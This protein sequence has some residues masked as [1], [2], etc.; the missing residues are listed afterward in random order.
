MF[1]TSESRNVS[2]MGGFFI[3]MGLVFGGAII[4]IVIGGGIFALMAGTKVLNIEQAMLNP[5]NVDALRLLQFIST[6]FMFF[7]PAVAFAYI[8]NKK[9]YKWLGY[10]EG[11]NYRQ[12]ILVLAV[13]FICLPLTGALAELNSIIPIPA[14]LEAKFKRMEENYEK[15]VEAVAKIRSFGEYLLSL[16]MIA[17][18]PALFEETLFRGGLQ[19]ILIE[20]TKKPITA[21]IV[22]SILFSIVHASYYGFLPRVGLGIVL[23]L[24]YYYS[25][26]I[27]LSVIAHCFNN[28]VVVSLMYYMSLH[29]KPSKE[30]LDQKFPIW[31]GIP[32][33]IL[34]VY[35][36]GR[37]KNVSFK[38]N[39]NAIPAMDAPSVHSDMA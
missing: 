29:G 38:R 1:E 27:W 28:A 23:G 21:I 26:S 8:M 9:P 22:T 13:M 34:L 19:R 7:L 25:K 24:I 35:L 12:A 16:F 10:K 2:P 14:S 6:L 11:F 5:A 39:I 20:W 32:V 18:L 17:I 4:G 15:Q 31:V 33:I 37:F 30:I 3:L 36:L